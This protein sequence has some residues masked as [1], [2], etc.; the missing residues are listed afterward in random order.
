M[1]K[2]AGFLTTD[3]VTVIMWYTGCILREL[4]SGKVVLD[5]ARHA[6]RLKADIDHIGLPGASPQRIVYHLA[7]T[8]MFRLLLEVVPAEI[9][10]S[11]E[12]HHVNI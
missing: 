5:G 10:Y 6:R 1:F 12:S 9:Y 11:A 8:D 2:K 3:Q 4:V 7:L